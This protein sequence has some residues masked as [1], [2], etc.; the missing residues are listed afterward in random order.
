MLVILNSKQWKKYI[1]AKSW[2]LNCWI[3]NN[4]IVVT[5]KYNLCLIYKF[6]KNKLSCSLKQSDFI[7]K[8]NICF[9][10]IFCSVANRHSVVNWRFASYS[11]VSR[12]ESLRV[13]FAFFYVKYYAC[14]RFA[15]SE[16][17]CFVC[18]VRFYEHFLFIVF[19]LWKMK[20]QK[21][22]HSLLQ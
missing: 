5:G 17:V 22:Y 10:L 2:Q 6:L 4:R 15:I 19:F 7:W 14:T 16:G 9:F 20:N 1:F 3:S 12:L 11:L 21:L 18:G 8:L 13:L